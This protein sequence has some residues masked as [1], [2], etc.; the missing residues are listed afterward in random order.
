MCADVPEAIF[1]P[2]RLKLARRRRGYTK[3]RLAEMAGITSKSLY[4]FEA[5]TA[6]PSNETLARIAEE[7]KFPTEFFER[8]ELD[9][10]VAMGASFRSMSKM[11]AS[12]RDAA[13]AAGTLALELGEWINHRFDLPPQNVP[14]LRDHEPEA[15]AEALRQRWKI[16][17]R[18]IGNMIHLLE[19]NGV[20]VFSLSEKGRHVDAF[21]VWRGT[22]PYVFLNTQKTAERSRMDAAHELGHLVLHRHGQPRGREA[23]SE[24]QSFGSAFLMP[25]GSV[26]ASAPRFATVDALV[27]L[28]A[29]WGVSVSALAYR[30][31]TLRMLTEWHYRTICI[32]IAQR[33]GKKEPAGIGRETSLLLNKVFEA[34]KAE[35]TTKATVAK[36]LGMYTPDLDALI[37]GLVMTA[38]DE[39]PTRRPRPASTPRRGAP[40]RLVSVRPGSHR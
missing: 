40:L 9:V 35:G 34:L 13:L 26:L 8:G 3:V 32:Q 14:D 27:R 11:T 22:T 24:A 25:R 23:E 33:F 18:P 17:E 38:A 16:G 30:L 2:S 12:Q 4:E 37:F 15:A 20:R 5:G 28:K 29:N 39:P 10:V 6:I 7:V 36:H 21:S 19:S 31:H 1:R